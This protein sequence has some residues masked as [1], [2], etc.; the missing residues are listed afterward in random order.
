MITQAAATSALGGLP[1]YI[2]AGVLN[3]LNACDVPTLRIV[4]AGVPSILANSGTVATNGTV[5]LGTALPAIYA[6][7]WIW[8]P[9]GAVVGGAA[10]LYFVKFSSTTV[11]QV[12][13]NYSAVTAD[14]IPAVPAG[15]LVNAVGS[16]AGY[17]GVT[18][19]DVPLA[20]VRI[21][22]N[23]VG[24]NGQLRARAAFANN[25]TA[26]TKAVKLIY[27]TATLVTLTN[28]TAVLA[29]L[30]ATMANRGIAAAQS[31]LGETALAASVVN[32]IAYSTQDSS[33]DL[34]F[35]ITANNNTATDHVVLEN[36]SV[37]VAQ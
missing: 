28:T 36:F 27:G 19:A 24:I 25:N 21:P 23:S 29:Q 30:R 17:T 20:Y 26:G 2:R 34:A 16:N 4:N 1:E 33:T 35:T 9:A 11:G 14:F 12:Y 10:G 8:L 5:T 6:N 7:A 3:Y 22:A 13:T 37:E 31:T 15:T 18:A 32:A